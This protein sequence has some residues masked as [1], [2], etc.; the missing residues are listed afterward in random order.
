MK[1]G[2]NISS[3]PPFGRLCTSRCSCQRGLGHAFLTKVYSFQQSHAPLGDFQAQRRTDQAKSAALMDSLLQMLSLLGNPST[4]SD[5][6]N[7]LL[8]FHSLW[9]L[10]EGK[11]ILA[12]SAYNF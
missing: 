4:G 6:E 12:L 9:L 8:K 1:A 3:P 10:H 5:A 2:G 11:S 7:K